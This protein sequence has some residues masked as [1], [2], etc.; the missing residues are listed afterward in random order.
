MEGRGGGEAQGVADPKRSIYTKHKFR[1]VRCRTTPCNLVRMDPY[2]GCMVLYDSVRHEIFCH[3]QG[4]PKNAGNF[5]NF[6]KRLS[7][8]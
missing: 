5:T 1:V 4:A 2:F 8:T 3:V 6:Q 7:V